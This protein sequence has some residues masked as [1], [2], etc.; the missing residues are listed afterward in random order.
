VRTRQAYVYL[1]A[2][3]DAFAETVPAGYFDA[4]Y[5][6]P[7]EA[8]AQHSLHVSRVQ[9]EKARAGAGDT[10]NIGEGP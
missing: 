9:F 7:D 2:I 1:T 10:Q 3:R 8:R 5:D 6:D 4:L